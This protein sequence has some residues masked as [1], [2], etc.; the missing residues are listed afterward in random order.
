MKRDSRIFLME[1]EDRKNR[2]V[3]DIHLI[4]NLA[5]TCPNEWSPQDSGEIIRA[6]EGALEEMRG[7]LQ[8]LAGEAGRVSLNQLNHQYGNAIYSEI[9]LKDL[10]GT[11]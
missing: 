9:R 3:K 4:G 5:H 1:A 11:K 7:V 8:N 10:C 2:A 6:L